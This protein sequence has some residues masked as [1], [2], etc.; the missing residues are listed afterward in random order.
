MVN[1]DLN[2]GDCVY[3]S[4]LYYFIKNVHGSKSARWKD[5]W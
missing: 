3:T 4:L 2:K 5:K 1:L